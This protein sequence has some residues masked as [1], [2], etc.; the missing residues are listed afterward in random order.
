HA[1][2]RGSY[3]E[4]G[5]REPLFSH[6]PSK[7]RGR[8]RTG[9][10]RQPADSRGNTLTKTLED[11]IALV[12]HRLRFFDRHEPSPDRKM[13]IDRLRPP[14]ILTPSTRGSGVYRN[15]M[16]SARCAKLRSWRVSINA[17][18][19]EPLRRKSA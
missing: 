17:K 6:R 12:L 5:E 1:D 18:R 10:A 11:W 7:A 15:P 8:G 3:G 16:A 2:N 4:R 14:P 19:Q 9:L 13:A